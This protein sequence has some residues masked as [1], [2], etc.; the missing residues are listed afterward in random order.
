[1]SWNP[2]GAAGVVIQYPARPAPAQCEV[3][4]APPGS[5]QCGVYQLRAICGPDG[6]RAALALQ[7]RAPPRHFHAGLTTGLACAPMR[8]Y[9]ARLYSAPVKVSGIKAACR[10][11]AHG[12]MHIATSRFRVENARAGGGCQGVETCFNN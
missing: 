2:C 7:L 3:T 6:P 1:M 11:C 8:T 5:R 12:G 4:A 9:T 10:I